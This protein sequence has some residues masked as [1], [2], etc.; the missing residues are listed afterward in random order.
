MGHERWEK[1]SQNP[2]GFVGAWCQCNRRAV[3]NQQ[4]VC[5]ELYTSCERSV[6]AGTTIGRFSLKQ[7]LLTNGIEKTA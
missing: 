3:R 7:L 2:E 4:R 6:E 5:F 1:I